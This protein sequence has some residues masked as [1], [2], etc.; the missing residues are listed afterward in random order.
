MLKSLVTSLLERITSR[1]GSLGCK[2]IPSPTDV[3]GV[4]QNLF[5]DQLVE[6]AFGDDEGFLLA[7]WM[8]E[9]NFN[10]VGKPLQPFQLFSGSIEQLAKATDDDGDYLIVFQN[11]AGDIGRTNVLVSHLFHPLGQVLAITECDHICR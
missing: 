5:G 4:R 10:D 11:L 1:S 8:T 7:V 3:V 6:L 2:P 9:F